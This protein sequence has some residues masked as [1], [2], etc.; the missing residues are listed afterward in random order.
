MIGKGTHSI[1]YLGY[2]AKNNQRVAIKKICLDH[3]VTNK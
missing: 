1:V 2:P 3:K